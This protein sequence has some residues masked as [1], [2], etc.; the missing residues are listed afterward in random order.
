MT[1]PERHEDGNFHFHMLINGL[2]P[3]QLG[4]V[5]SGKV[6]CSWA[7]KKTDYGVE[8]IGYC[9]REHFEKTKQFQKTIVYWVNNI[10]FHIQRLFKV[11]ANKSFNNIWHFQD[12]ETKHC[13]DR[14]LI[15]LNENI[16]DVFDNQ[17][18]IFDN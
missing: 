4:L 2:T 18:S 11:C 1:F 13:L 16:D 7:K 8:K 5:N 6:C 14:G 12:N 9:S 10:R 17:I 15:P 3:K